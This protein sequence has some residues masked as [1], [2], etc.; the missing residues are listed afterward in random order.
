MARKK[1]QWS[2]D[3][4]NPA[5][6]A[7]N[8]VCL[9]LLR[10]YRCSSAALSPDAI[11]LNEIIAPFWP[12]IRTDAVHLRRALLGQTGN[13]SK[14]SSR[15]RETARDRQQRELL[16][17]WVTTRSS[18]EPIPVEAPD[19]DVMQ[20][21]AEGL[22][23]N[24]PSFRPLFDALETR[25]E[26][27]ISTQR[28]DADDNISML[29]ALLDLSATERAL[30]TLCCAIEAGTIGSGPF[31]RFRRPS[32][33]VQ[34][35]MG[36]LQL[37]NDHEVGEFL[38][39]QSQLRR[40][41]LL[42]REGCYQNDLE[43]ALRLTRQGSALV[44][45]TVRSLEDMAAVVLKP[46]PP[47]KA[48]IPL[49]WPHLEERSV[50][51]K[52]LLTNV[53][54]KEERGI[55]VLFYGGPGTGKTEYAAHLIGSI[56]AQGYR[57]TDA[58]DAETSASRNERL[59]SLSLTQIFSPAK[60][61]VL[62]LDEAEDIFQSD[63]NNPLAR[64]FGKKE[65]S[66]LWMNSLLES[67]Q[68]PV[69]WI[70]NQVGHID[71]AYLRRFTYC[72]EFPTTPRAVR[73][74]IAHAHLDPVGCSAALVETVASH[75]DV[76]PALLASGARFATLTAAGPSIVDSAVRHMLADNL[77]AMGKELAGNIPERATRFDMRYL[78]VKGQ[79]DAKQVV[80]GLYRAGRG[81]LLLSGPPGT[82]KTQLA[83]EIAQRLG[84]ELIYKTASD[85]NTMWF[86]ESE[87]N[88]ARMFTDCDPG[89]EV[90][91]LDEADTLLGSRDSANH[92]ADLAVTAE[93][94]RRVEAFEGVFVCA[95]NHP[96]QLDSALMR[97]FTFRMA[98]QAMTLKQRQQ[99]LW[100]TALGW[101]P[102]EP[103][104][105]LG[106][107]ASLRLGRLDQLTPGDFANVVKRARSL[108]VNLEIDEWLSELEA[109]HETKP[110]SA[111]GSIGFL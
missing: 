21:L 81:T 92:R 20:R 10:I 37:S 23:F 54:R 27:L 50:L 111:G 35:L 25:L 51:L 36:G 57:I 11:D 28:T 63:Y 99:M 83:A 31:E 64:V 62:V 29:A 79:L 108:Q 94:L 13:S 24:R 4:A 41:G 47:G 100:E 18:Q 26:E 30:L 104:P 96:R 98:F 68:K 74:A 7:N 61:S 32:H 103:E 44:G 80:A 66:K 42:S 86:G 1:L 76:S 52:A 19:M 15:R 78:N 34:A 22:I 6:V 69:I 12:L 70:S 93:F 16:P 60:R 71:P 65:G 14:A 9:V 88:V 43:E 59:A 84:R 5:S 38:S 58:D 85:I 90:L 101:T 39:S 105:Q 49:S 110:Q 72:L 102:S 91:F 33:Q 55:N 2:P 48:K 46:L 107:E 77:K 56:G 67:N 8:R 53:L 82:G 73:R 87:R 40:S 75:E 89:N 17:E 106:P 97:R 45:T 109:E 95:T 3:S